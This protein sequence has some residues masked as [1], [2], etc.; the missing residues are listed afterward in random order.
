M[1]PTISDP[2]MISS[3][4]DHLDPLIQDH[5]IRVQRVETIQDFE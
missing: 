1:T 4:S 5:V 2:E 3:L